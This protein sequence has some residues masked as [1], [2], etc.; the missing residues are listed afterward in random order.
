MIQLIHSTKKLNGG[1]IVKKKNYLLEDLTTEEIKYIRGIIWK[2]VRRCKKEEHIRNKIEGK[3]IFD[4]DVKQ[5]LL[6]VDDKYDYRD[7]VLLN[8]FIKILTNT[9]CIQ[10]I[11]EIQKVKHLITI[12]V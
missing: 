9:I 7:D 10:I 6:T 5:R 1:I 11:G 4:E 3:S 8:C 2:T 12:F